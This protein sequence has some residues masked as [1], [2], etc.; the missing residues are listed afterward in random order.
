MSTLCLV[1]LTQFAL[2][3][4]PKS[5]DVSPTNAQQNAV[6]RQQLTDC[7]A[8]ILDPQGRP[9]ER[10][11]WA[12]TLFSYD[13]PPSRAL[14]IEI[15]SLNNQPKAQAALCSV[16]RQRVSQSTSLSDV[17]L[18]GPLMDI[19]NAPSEEARQAAAAALAAFRQGEVI[20]KLGKL[21]TDESSPLAKRIAA[22]D[23][24]A[25]NIDR[26]DAVGE[27]I[28]I[29]EVKSLPVLAKALSALA[30]A[31][32]E[33]LGADVNAWQAWWENKSQ[34][35]EKA[36]LVDRLHLYLRRLSTVEDAYQSYREDAEQ[37]L[38][39]ITTKLRDYQRE[40]FAL[41]DPDQRD[42]KLIEWLL[43]PA[44]EVKLV[45]MGI[46]KG[47]IADEG[48]RPSNDILRSLLT[49]LGDESPAIRREV[50]IIVQTLVDPEIEKALLLRIDEEHDPVTRETLFRAIGRLNTT[51]S[52][53]YLV[54]EIDTPDS[55]TPCVR[56][57]AIALAQTANMLNDKQRRPAAAALKR[58]YALAQESEVEL[59]A[60]LLSAMA[61]VAEASF[62]K[63]FQTSVDTADS[64]L[65]RPAIRGLV[66][67]GDHS[68][69]ARIRALSADA[70]AL[71][72]R[73]AVEALGVLGR[74]DADLEGVLS[75]LNPKTETNDLV[76]A[77]AWQ[78][79]LLLVSDKAAQQQFSA[80]QG[81]R[82][83]PDLEIRYLSK[84][85]DNISQDQAAYE[86]LEQVNVRLIDVLES[87][88]QCAASIPYRQRMYDLRIKRSQTEPSQSHDNELIEAGRK[89][90]L[91]A[92][93]C[94]AAKADVGSVLSYLLV[95]SK[96][97]SGRRAMIDTMETWLDAQDWSTQRDRLIG[98]SESFRSIS[99]QPTEDD[100]TQ[101]LQRINKQIEDTPKTALPNQ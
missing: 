82:E 35:G 3:Q 69:N 22:I 1:W 2:A 31:T 32:L 60:A 100:W 94:Q 11:R 43:D 84:L 63:E 68:R 50:L 64:L 79:F 75:R 18:V 39:L 10:R 27:L 41:S 57:A 58:R 77:A 7:R 59:R 46:I 14:V 81:L 12:R 89:W 71:V 67:L 47:H 5:S 83:F 93:D 37:R 85:S 23:A 65:I 74:E 96:D 49:L 21:C 34:L 26:I 8:G 9:A 86:I 70:N 48:R 73:D 54:R 51:A 78:A 6:H 98:I 97:A 4:T 24:L 38:N 53:P 101:L 15:L 28:S 36:W 80:A 90:L 95:T 16:I 42:A 99:P 66:A 40:I 52:I 72:R 33:P 62:K 88:D 56:E 29:L 87:Q 76:Q 19:L 44:N 13:S 92:L 30:P 20:D 45:A 55:S 61:G 91:A 25:P 17:I